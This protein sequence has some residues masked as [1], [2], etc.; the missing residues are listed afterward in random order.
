MLTSVDGELFSNDC[1]VVLVPPHDLRIYLIQKNAS[2]SL[3]LEAS[4]QNWQI[5]KNVDVNHLDRVDVF[6]REPRSRILSGINTFVQHLVRDNPK[7]DPDTCLFIACKYLF[8]NR[9]Y[10]PQWHWIVNLAR[11]IDSECEI[12]LHPLEYLEKVTHLRS[13][14]LITPMDESDKTKVLGMCGNIDLWLLLDQI[15]LG[16]CGQSFTWP[17]LLELYRQHPARP[18]DMVTK[19]WS[20]ITRVL[21]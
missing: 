9:H 20:E 8:L 7:L 4:A 16:H 3:R 17:Q 15:L 1:E 2:S 14:A 19:T 10:L 11:I 13:R 18:L 12:R 21:R 5:L 6:I